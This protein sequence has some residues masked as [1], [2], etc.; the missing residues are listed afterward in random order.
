MFKCGYECL[1]DH[2][3]IKEGEKCVEDCGRTLHQ[4]MTIVQNEIT[5]FQ[6]CIRIIYNFIYTI[7]LIP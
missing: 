7:S 1:D 5:S 2:R 6:V 3:T 4:A